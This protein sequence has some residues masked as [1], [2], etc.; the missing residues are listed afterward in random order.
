MNRPFFAIL[1]V[2]ALGNA[3]AADSMKLTLQEAVRMALAQNHAL[4]IARL[5]VIE[6]EQKKAGAKADYFPKI[7]NQSNVLHATSLENIE[8]PA[9][10]LRWIWSL[11]RKPFNPCDGAG[12]SPVGHGA[13]V[14]RP[15]EPSGRLRLICSI[16]RMRAW[17]SSVRVAMA[18]VASRPGLRTWV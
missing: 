10:A 5:K 16:S 18:V 14:G 11:I 7:K 12:H 2:C 3:S 17:R 6:N 1:F 8:I 15:K 9:G 13:R 4:K